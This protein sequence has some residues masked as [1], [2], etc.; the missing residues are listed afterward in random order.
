MR[1]TSPSRPPP[2]S[3]PPEPVS[4]RPSVD[5][6]VPAK[7]RASGPSSG[8][9]LGL[10]QPVPDEVAILRARKQVE[11]V[12]GDELEAAREPRQF[13]S[14]ADRLT[15]LAAQSPDDLAAEYE[16]EIR[17]WLEELD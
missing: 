1:V 17:L 10:R 12:L 4:K 16:N 8:S 5:T 14:L 13:V 3:K 11:R 6:E 7:P 2:G 9:G 15:A